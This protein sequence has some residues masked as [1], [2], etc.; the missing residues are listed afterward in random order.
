[1]VTAGPPDC[2]LVSV[3]PSWNGLWD[4]LDYERSRVGFRSSSPTERAH[5]HEAHVDLAV[6]MTKL[7]SAHE[8]P[9]LPE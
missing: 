2:P 8:L 6:Q 9:C 3:V 1:M 5:D 7:L 4:T